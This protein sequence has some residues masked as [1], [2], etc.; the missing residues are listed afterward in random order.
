MWN[1]EVSAGERSHAGDRGIDGRGVRSGASRHRSVPPTQ[2]QTA[3]PLA[4][5]TAY[6]NNNNNYQAPAIPGPLANPTPGTV[7]VHINGKVQTTFQS[8][9]TSGDTSDC[10]SAPAA[11]DQ[12]VRVDTSAVTGAAS[13]R[14]QKVLDIRPELWSCCSFRTN[15]TAGLATV[16]R[17][18]RVY[19]VR[20]RANGHHVRRSAHTSNKT[21]AVAFLRRMLTEYATMARGDSPRR[22]Y[23]EAVERFLS[24]AAFKPGTRVAY[25]CCHKAFRPLMRE[26]L[27]G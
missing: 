7:V 8:E 9:W 24:E 10:C 4:N 18:G 26:P 14:N 13:R 3:Y 5:P 23:E 20:F 17:R 25:R 22:R 2:G 6:V 12:P 27:L 1:A 19:W 15:E 16:Y 11:Q 21:E